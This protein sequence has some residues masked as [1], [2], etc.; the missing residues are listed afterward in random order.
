MN[1]K[2]VYDE[3]VGLQKAFAVADATVWRGDMTCNFLTMSKA[4]RVLAR[5]VRRLQEEASDD[6]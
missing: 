2:Y 3:Q 5:E 4:A 1:D 6:S